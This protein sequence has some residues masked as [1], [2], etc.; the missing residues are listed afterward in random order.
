MNY[1][2]ATH[3]SPEET[4]RLAERFFGPAGLGL[5]VQARRRDSLELAG[6][7]GRVSLRVQITDGATEAFLTT[8]GLDYQVRQFMVEIYEE[9]HRH[10]E[11]EDD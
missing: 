8:E 9:A 3:F 6:P 4:L 10:G 2:T 5:E 7:R 11:T 1:G